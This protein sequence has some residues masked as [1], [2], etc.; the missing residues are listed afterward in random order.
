M[1]DQQ[2][3]ASSAIANS[4]A[5]T[6]VGASLYEQD[7]YLWVQH[8]IKLLRDGQFSELDI[9]NLIEEVEDMGKSERR[10]VESNLEIILMQLLK[11]KYQPQ[12]RSHSWRYTILE[13]RDRLDKVFA[14]SPS[15]AAYFR[16]VFEHCYVKARR[17]AAT[18]TGLAIEMFPTESPFTP[19]ETLNPDYL[20]D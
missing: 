18:E 17:K 13:H 4:T 11:Y 20:P 3:I 14:D 9:P 16:Q 19:E 2:P 6:P 12:S 10:S 8:T 7:Y 5:A 15:L 1:S